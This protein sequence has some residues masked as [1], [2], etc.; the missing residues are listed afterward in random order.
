MT[1][2]T[3]TTISRRFQ[4]SSRRFFEKFPVSTLHTTREKNKI[5]FTIYVKALIFRTCAS[6]FAKCKVGYEI[7]VM[8]TIFT[9]CWKFLVNFIDTTKQL[10]NRSNNEISSVGIF[11]NLWFEG[12]TICKILY[13]FLEKEKFYLRK[14]SDEYIRWMR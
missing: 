2:M 9:V 5:T 6:R 3:L 13:R 4:P 1:M 7:L 10:W 12:I 11:R 14:C 8:K